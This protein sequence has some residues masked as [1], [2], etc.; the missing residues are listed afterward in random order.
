MAPARL[1]VRFCACLAV[2]A[3][4]TSARCDTLQ[5]ALAFSEQNTDTFQSDLLALAA[6]PTISALPEHRDDVVK[7]SEWLKQR[8]KNMGMENVQVR[9]EPAGSQMLLQTTGRR[10]RQLPSCNGELAPVT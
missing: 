2:L 7:G 4:A 1:C 6:I 3:F 8:L 10:I 5:T 9:S